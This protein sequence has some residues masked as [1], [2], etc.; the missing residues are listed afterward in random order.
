VSGNVTA[1]V[2][3]GILTLP[4]PFLVII[5]EMGTRGELDAQREDEQK[6]A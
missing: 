1:E 3:G 4:I 2:L 5:Q 6:L